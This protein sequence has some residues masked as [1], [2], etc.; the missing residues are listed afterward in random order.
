MSCSNVVS[1]EMLK[2][3][4]GV[5][6]GSVYVGVGGSHVESLTSVARGD[7]EH[8]LAAAE[9]DEDRRQARRAER[10]DGVLGRRHPRRGRGPDRLYAGPQPAVHPGPGATVV[11]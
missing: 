10:A 3:M 7:A 5:E 11:A 1:P 8:R 6:I 2:T 4:A 9:V